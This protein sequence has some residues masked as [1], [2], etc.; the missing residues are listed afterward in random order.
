M[1][2]ERLVKE[3]PNDMELGSKVRELYL[4][5]KNTF[6]RLNEDM[7]DAFIFES[8]DGGKTVFVRGW[9][10]DISSRTEVKKNKTK[11]LTI[12]DDEAYKESK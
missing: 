9:G 11:Q 3:Y 12:F 2:I 10:A 5:N 1:D 7:K 8:P 6:E 4:K